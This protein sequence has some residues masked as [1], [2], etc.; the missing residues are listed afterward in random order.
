MFLDID[1]ASPEAIALLTSSQAWFFRALPVS[2]K[3]KHVVIAIDNDTISLMDD[4]QKLL[5]K[6][7]IIY[8]VNQKSLEDELRRHYGDDKVILDY[9][10]R[11]WAMMKDQ[12]KS[13]QRKLEYIYILIHYGVLEGATHITILKEK[14]IY[15]KKSGLILKKWSGKFKGIGPSVSIIEKCLGNPFILTFFENKNYSIRSMR[16][17]DMIEL[18]IT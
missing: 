1:K 2:I 15:I 3:G 13:T 12:S 7:I 9:S 4:L 16:N 14:N 18:D 17:G 6:K 10:S 8:P 5:G 11:F